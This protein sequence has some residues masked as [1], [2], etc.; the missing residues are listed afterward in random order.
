MKSIITMQPPRMHSH[1]LQPPPPPLKMLHSFSVFASAMHAL[2]QYCSVSLVFFFLLLE[3]LPLLLH[4]HLHRNYQ[5]YH[6]STPSIVCVRRTNQDRSNMHTIKIAMNRFC[7]WTM[8]ESQ[9][10]EKNKEH[11]HLNL[12]QNVPCSEVCNLKKKWEDS[13]C[14]QELYA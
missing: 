9:K 11:T 4:S 12:I 1:C 6:L 8:L 3:T 7:S 2:T 10:R 5:L 13:V 14:I